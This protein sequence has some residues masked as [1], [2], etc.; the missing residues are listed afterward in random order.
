[1]VNG[2]IKSS[3]LPSIR[4][5]A[6]QIDLIVMDCHIERFGVHKLRDG[7]F[8]TPST[9]LIQS[10]V[11]KSLPSVPPVVPVGTTRHTMFWRNAAKRFLDQLELI[12]LKEQLIVIN[13]PWAEVD[14]KGNPFGLNRGIPVREMSEH[15][16]ALTT[17]MRDRDVRV[18]D[19]PPAY[20][21]APVDHQWGAGPFHFG[22]EAMG[23]V[24]NQM[25]GALD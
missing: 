6:D 20:A 18:L 10:G 12:G 21:I 1:M 16:T 25:L 11:L 24:A 15:I 23:W 2:D 19:M 5:V 17:V 9:E 22:R 14:S 7:S 13:A 8:V 3:L 4:R